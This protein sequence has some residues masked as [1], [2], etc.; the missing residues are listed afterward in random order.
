VN[1][2]QKP[3]QQGIN[4]TFEKYFAPENANHHHR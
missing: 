4:S 2:L 1:K 3:R